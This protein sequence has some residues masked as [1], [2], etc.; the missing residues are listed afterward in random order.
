MDSNSMLSSVHKAVANA[1]HAANI[2]R[3][4]RIRLNLLAKLPD[5]GVDGFVSGSKVSSPYVFD[6]L[7]VGANPAEIL[8]QIG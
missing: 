4:L 2:S 6:Y 7:I 3:L 5:V 1:V 8:N